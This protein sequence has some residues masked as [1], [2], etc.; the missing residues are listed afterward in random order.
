MR[1]MAACETSPEDVSDMDDVRRLLAK[2]IL[3]RDA[4]GGFSLQDDFTDAEGVGPEEGAELNA[5]VERCFEVAGREGEDLYSVGMELFEAMGVDRFDDWNKVGSYHVLELPDGGGKERAIFS[6]QSYGEARAFM[7][8]AATGQLL[9]AGSTVALVDG[10]RGER[11]AEGPDDAATRPLE[12]DGF[13]QPYRPTWIC[14]RPTD[15]ET[16]R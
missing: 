9:A 15:T 8:G 14:G 13:D 4:S 6:S 12:L 10:I 2:L 3:E 16:H 7:L 1:Y 5:L 11:S